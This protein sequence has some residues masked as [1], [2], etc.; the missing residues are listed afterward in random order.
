VAVLPPMVAVWLMLV[1]P[2]GT[3]PVVVP[4]PF[5]TAVAAA[6]AGMTGAGVAPPCGAADGVAGADGAGG[7]VGVTLALAAEAADMPTRFVAVTTKV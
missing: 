4:T 3:V 5:F 7:A 1:A 6:M 2:A